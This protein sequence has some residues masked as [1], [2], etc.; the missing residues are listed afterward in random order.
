MLR[1]TFCVSSFVLIVAASVFPQQVRYGT[2][3]WDAA[4]LG[5]HRAVLRVAVTT[6]AV[7]AHIPWRRRD[8]EPEKKAIIVT[9]QSGLR[10]PNVLRIEVNRYYGDLVF[11]VPS[12]G[13]YYVYFLPFVSKGR[14]Y[15][16]VTY[17]PPEE[18]ADPVWEKN[19][20]SA[21]LRS[22]RRLPQAELVEIQS[23]DEFNSFYPMEII[24][25]PEEVDT[26]HKL[27][28]SR[29]YFLFPEDRRFPIRMTGDLPQ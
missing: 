17:P 11:Q 5:N 28:S 26:L 7:W 10:I 21:L 18:T 27:N 2:G 16:V 15:P 22:D 12:Q 9:N 1:V 25:T 3:S 19:A 13:T 29:E 23:V 4:T 24:A 14:N 20:R 8:T 6:D